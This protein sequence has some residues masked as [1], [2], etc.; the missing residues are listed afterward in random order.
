MINVLLLIAGMFLETTAALLIFTP[1]LT[2]VILALDVDLIHF[3]VFMMVNLVIGMITPPVGI[4]M[5]VAAG[6]GRVS[7]GRMMKWSV[8]CILVL[9]LALACITFIPAITM[10]LPT[11]MM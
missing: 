2:P 7:I 10:L 4:N 5:F 8:A 1:L 11:T 6:V 9:I 3:G